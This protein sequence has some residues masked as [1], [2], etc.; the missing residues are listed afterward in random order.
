MIV[1]Y[2]IHILLGAVAGFAGASTADPTM[3]FASF[4]QLP[5]AAL[6]VSKMNKTKPQ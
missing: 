4:V 1:I 3:L 6:A 2:R 5:L